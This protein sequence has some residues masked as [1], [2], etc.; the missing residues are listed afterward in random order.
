MTGFDIR[1]QNAEHFHYAL[2]GKLLAKNIARI[3]RIHSQKRMIRFGNP[4]LK[5][6]PE[7]LVLSCDYEDSEDGFTGIKIHSQLKELR[8]GSWE[9]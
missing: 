6:N 9:D 4:V 5:W 7:T 2:E 3:G 8:E 1:F